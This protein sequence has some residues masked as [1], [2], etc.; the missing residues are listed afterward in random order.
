MKAFE[1]WKKKNNV[2]INICDR[3]ACIET[4]EHCYTV[5]TFLRVLWK[6]AWKSAIKQVRKGSKK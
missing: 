4:T 6:E 1:N 3:D 5:D 2:V